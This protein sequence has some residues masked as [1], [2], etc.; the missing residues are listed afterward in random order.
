MLVRYLN[1]SPSN[2]VKFS[3]DS[4]HLQRMLPNAFQD[5]LSFCLVPCGGKKIT[6]LGQI[7]VKPKRV[8]LFHLGQLPSW[9]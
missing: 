4:H 3:M 7:A 9:C 2:A 6:V 8:I 5:L 1:N